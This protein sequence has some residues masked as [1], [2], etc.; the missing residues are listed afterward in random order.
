[1]KL[2]NNIIGI[3]F[4]KELLD[5]F[6]DTKTLIIGILIPLVLLPVMFGVIGSGMNKSNKDVKDNIKITIIDKGNSTIRD[7]FK[8]QK[9]ISI[10]K[11]TNIG[12]DVKR[13]TI[14]IAMEIPKDFDVAIK[15][16]KPVN[17]KLTYDN[18]SQQS[19]LAVAMID[20][21][22]QTYSKSIIGERLRSRGI[23]DEILNPINIYKVTLVKESES[24]GQFMISL[25]LPLFLMIYS[26]TG[27]IWHP[28]LTLVLEKRREER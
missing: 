11:S 25:L 12:E 26:V 14:M 20:S 3:V 24:E 1:M 10:I 23:K 7:F 6:R 28:Q 13:G 9:N 15:S 2:K 4:K 5:I 8:S 17:I 19:N 18:A 27:P 22:I 16:E 21:Y